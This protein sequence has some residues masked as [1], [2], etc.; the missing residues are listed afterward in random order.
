MGLSKTLQKE[1]MLEKPVFT[2]LPFVLSTLMLSAQDMDLGSQMP[3]HKYVRKDTLANGM[4]YYLFQTEVVD[5][6]ASY[7][8][9]QN[10]GSVLENENQLGLAHFLEHMAFNGTEHFKG[11]VVL[12]TLEQAGAVL[13][14]DVNAH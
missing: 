12:N 13:G 6:V 7:Y 4:T 9:V 3:A 14:R 5:N 1:L 10:V 8:L 11:K 2:I